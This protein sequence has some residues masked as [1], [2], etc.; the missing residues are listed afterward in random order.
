[1]RMKDEEE[2]EA[3]AVAAA[4]WDTPVGVVA[5][6]AVAAAAAE[7][8]IGTVAAGRRSMAATA[9]AAGR[10]AD[11]TRTRQKPLRARRARYALREEQQKRVG[12]EPGLRPRPWTVCPA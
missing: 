3:V 7:S 6:A 4:S 12:P 11:K 1:L 8:G 5:A 10:L 9:G 2:E